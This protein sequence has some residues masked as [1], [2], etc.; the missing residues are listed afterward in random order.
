MMFLGSLK[1]LS[2]AAAGVA[3]ARVPSH[4][5]AE[6]SPN[7]KD[8]SRQRSAEFPLG[9]HWY[10]KLRVRVMK[11]RHEAGVRHSISEYTV[12]TRL[13][14]DI[15]SKCFTDEDNTDV[16]STDTQKN[17]VYVVA[18]RT[19]ASSPE[20]FGVEIAKHFINEYPVLNGV[21][22]IVQEHPWE[23]V[24]IDGEPHD[25]GFIKASAEH[26]VATVKLTRDRRWDPQVT[27]GI[28]GMT[29]LKT[30]Q[31]GWEKFLKD[32]FT[33]LGDTDDRCMSTQVTCDWTYMPKSAGVEPD[34]LSVRRNVKEQMKLGFFGPA[35]GGVYSTSVQATVYDIGCMVLGSTPDVANITINTPNL[36]YLPVTVL[37]R[38]GEK[39]ENDIFL[40]TSEPSGNIQCTVERDADGF[41]P[42][43]K[44]KPNEE[45]IKNDIRAALINLKANAC[46]M[47]MRVAWHASGTWDGSTGTGGSDGATMRFEPEFSDG[48]N[49]GLTMMI[50][51]LKPVKDKNPEVSR[52][53]IWALA[54]CAAI[55]F[56]GGPKVPFAFGRTDATGQE[57]GCP[58]LTI[59]ENGRLPDA[60]KGAA[61]LREVF[62]RQGFNDRDIVALSGGHT[63]GRCHKV[64]SGYDG[65]WTDNPLKFDNSYY[66]HLMDLDWQRRNWDGKDQYE[67]VA[68]KRLV[69]LPTDMA[70]KTDPAFSKVAREYADNQEAFFKDFALA[71]SKLL[72]NGCR[73]KPPEL[74]K[75]G[76]CTKSSPP[77]TPKTVCP[78]AK[79]KAGLE[80][81]EY[82]MHGSTE[83]MRTYGQVADVHETEEN[84]GRTALHK[85][86]FWGHIETITCLLDEYKLDPNVQDASGD[87]ALHDAVRFGHAPLVEKLLASGA[88][89][90]VKNKAG[91]DAETVAIDYGKTAIATQLAMHK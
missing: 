73:H 67:D 87:T 59:P 22:I 81:R 62:Y 7:R 21:E 26:A 6:D 74:L 57:K 14:S 42:Q 79:K 8:F 46:P 84:S 39:F 70:L 91:K 89:K 13:Y 55:E 56:L 36:H 30:T 34:Y 82:A 47:A 29:V 43:P 18:K 76:S 4:C 17:N 64:R 25:H 77:P 72:H 28:R 63:L 5:L 41:A 80:F 40:P 53:D 60:S 31:S 69:M 15:Y 85:A 27:S 58:A 54:G 12:E 75:S 11:V 44:F 90:N 10:G 20:Q 35:I 9:S 38:V 68:T 45:A 24:S 78:K 83:R 23:R 86:A 16:V 33:T 48:A 66:K 1:R 32:R 52:A 88:D 61:H 19:A 51:M 49:A 37:E 65:P 3:A 2:A 71:F 50:D